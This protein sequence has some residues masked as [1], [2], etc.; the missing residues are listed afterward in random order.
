VISQEQ[1]KP[2]I[3]ALGLDVGHKRIGIAGCDGTGLIAT[4]ITTVERRSFEQD[5]QQI[6]NIVNERRVQVLV[7][8]LPYSMDGSLG[9][10][11]RHVQKFSTRLAKALQ[12]PVEYVDERLT[13]FQ[14]EQ[15]LIAENRSPSRHKAL[16]DRKAASIILQQWL[17]ARRANFRSSVAAIEY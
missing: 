13:S 10:Q 16:I 6:Q 14:A 15:M 9:F 3:S 12:L 7:I 8:G 17:D 2:F 5:V 1:P 4:G 11:A